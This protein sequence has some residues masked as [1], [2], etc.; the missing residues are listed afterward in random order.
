[1]PSC[2][3]KTTHFNALSD[4]IVIRG[5]VSEQSWEIERGVCPQTS[6]TVN[7]RWFRRPCKR[8]RGVALDCRASC[9]LLQ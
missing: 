4:D 9:P 6:D 3:C 7:A 1:M 2:R 8:F 5:T